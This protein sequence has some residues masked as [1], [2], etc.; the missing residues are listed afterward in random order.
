MME[1]KTELPQQKSKLRKQLLE[2]FPECVILFDE[3][4]KNEQLKLLKAN[5][6]FINLFQTKRNP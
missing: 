4:S 5:K 3:V 2:L 6:E 1:N